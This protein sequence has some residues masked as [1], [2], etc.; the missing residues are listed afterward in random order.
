MNNFKIGPIRRSSTF[1]KI[2]NKLANNRFMLAYTMDMPERFT[3][4]IYV[5][6]VCFIPSNTPNA[7]IVSPK[8]FLKNNFKIKRRLTGH[9]K[10]PNS[11]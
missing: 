11:E 3:K 1:D 2:I 7:R 8:E 4:Y 6:S 10:I 9:F 5:G